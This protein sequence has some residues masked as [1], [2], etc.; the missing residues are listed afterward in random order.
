MGVVF[1]VRH[2]RIPRLGDDCVYCNSRG[3]ELKGK[4]FCEKELRELLKK[5]GYNLV[6]VV[7]E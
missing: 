7:K 1:V 6:S 5:E 2:R 3:V 4:W